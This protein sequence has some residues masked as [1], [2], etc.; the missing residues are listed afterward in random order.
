MCMAFIFLYLYISVIVCKYL[1][2]YLCLTDLLHFSTSLIWNFLILYINSEPVFAHEKKYQNIYFGS[3]L[4]RIFYYP[5]LTM[6]LIHL[7]LGSYCV[8]YQK[9][10]FWFLHFKKT[11]EKQYHCFPLHCDRKVIIWHYSY[12]VFFFFLGIDHIFFYSSQIQNALSKYFS[13]FFLLSIPG[14]E[15]TQFWIYQCF[16]FY[17]MPVIV[18][19]T[20]W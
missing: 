20:I 9:W 14:L 6:L 7:T 12:V 13:V 3:E 1:H 8:Q 16:Y 10:F 2:T 4:K 15:T 19:V 11:H 5:T 18:N 17:L